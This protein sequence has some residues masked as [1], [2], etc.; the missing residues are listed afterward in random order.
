MND[1]KTVLPNASQYVGQP[2]VINKA[3]KKMD[4]PTIVGIVIGVAVAATAIG[5]MVW[6]FTK[7]K[8]VKQ[9]GKTGKKY[10]KSSKLDYV[11]CIVQPKNWSS[12]NSCTKPVKSN[13]SAN[14]SNS[15][16][17]NPSAKAQ[18]ISVTPDNIASIMS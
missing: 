4:V 8:S 3:P 15:P 9:A 18:R 6:I 5:L 13:P 2:I 1:T 7:K 12:S 17:S 16:N 10:K 11:K 14:S